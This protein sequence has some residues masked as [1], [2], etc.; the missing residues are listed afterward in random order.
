MRFS[1]GKELL[2]IKGKTVKINSVVYGDL[3]PP[4]IVGRLGLWF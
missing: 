4:W 2:K 1:F 3:G